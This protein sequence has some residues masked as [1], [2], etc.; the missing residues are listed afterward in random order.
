[1]AQKGH[2][3]SSARP[4]SSKITSY[5]ISRGKSTVFKRA[6]MLWIK[7]AEYDVTIRLAFKRRGI[8]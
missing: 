7:C 3:S 6:E 1:M 2:P 8:H 5:S 4:R